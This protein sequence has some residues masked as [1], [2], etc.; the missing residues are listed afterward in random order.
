MLAKKAAEK[1]KRE[2]IDRHARQAEQMKRQQEE[3]KKWLENF[4][5]KFTMENFLETV[6]EEKVDIPNEGM[7][8]MQSLPSGFWSCDAMDYLGEDKDV[9]VLNG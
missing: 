1:A 2:A 4:L 9:N 3:E 8:E 5:A 7:C 6:R